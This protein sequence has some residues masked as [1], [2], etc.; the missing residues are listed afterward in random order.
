M[1]QVFRQVLPYTPSL[2]AL[3][4]SSL[5]SFVIF[6]HIPNSAHVLTDPDHFGI[7]GRNLFEGAGFS[8]NGVPTLTKGPIYPFVIS[9]LFKLGGAPSLVFIQAFQCVL[10]SLGAYFVHQLSARILL[11]D[12]LAF[13]TAL[14]FSLHP[15]LHWYA[16]RVWL[17]IVLATLLLAISLAFVKLLERPTLA[18]S[19][20][21][22][23]LLGVAILTKSVFILLPPLLGFFLIMAHRNR[24]VIAY[25]ALII[26]ASY[27]IVAPWTMRNY[28][29][30]QQIIPVHLNLGYNLV[31]GEWV[32]RNFFRTPL[33]FGTP[34]DLADVERSQ[35][36]FEQF[37]NA[38]FSA[39]PELDVDR[40]L[41]EV[42]IQRITSEP[43]RFVKRIAI[44]SATFW[45]LGDTPPKTLAII[46][47]QVPLLLLAGA[48]LF[49]LW[50]RVPLI[51]AFLALLVVYYW[52]LHG[53]I[54]GA[55]RYS[56]PLIPLLL[57]FAVYGA[58][59]WRSR[60][61]PEDA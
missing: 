54:V 47:L 2:V 32:E 20:V 60:H 22:G 27:L 48:G 58:A 19:L 15:L 5:Y 36:L 43:I 41:T 29:V 53:A 52:G 13:F 35:L 55:F 37:G 42:S 16:P 46:G 8:E 44:N 56:M 21:C 6:P 31:I 10:L 7:V 11:S 28:I 30:S 45:Y 50:R 1:S 4:I 49:K 25:S 17:E 24:N 61:Q 14:L 39:L 26:A 9:L 51:C 57:P 40:Y 59:S 3:L 34:W 38:D 23:A 12:R 33:S 18:L